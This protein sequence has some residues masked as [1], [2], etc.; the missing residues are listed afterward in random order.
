M[1]LPSQWSRVG[2]TMIHFN[3]CRWNGRLQRLCRPPHR[4]PKSS[5]NLWGK[6][7][8]IMAN[9]CESRGMTSLHAERPKMRSSRRRKPQRLVRLDFS[10]RRLPPSRRC[11]GRR[12]PQCS[13][14]P[15]TRI[16]AIF[17]DGM[18]IVGKWRMPGWN[19]NRPSVNTTGFGMSGI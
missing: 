18:C 11:R 19:S 9:V 6:P 15:R 13:C 12:G 17:C 16:K 10:K 14:G 4:A 1:L 7:T 3:P 8:S 5:T 2:V